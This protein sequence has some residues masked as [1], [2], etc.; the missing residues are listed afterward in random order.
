MQRTIQ[1][2]E[3]VESN[4]NFSDW[5]KNRDLLFY[6]IG[7]RWQA[8]LLYEEELMIFSSEYPPVLRFIDNKDN[9]TGGKIKSFEIEQLSFSNKYIKSNISIGL[10]QLE[11][12]GYHD[13][14]ITDNTKASFRFRGFIPVNHIN[15]CIIEFKEIDNYSV[16]EFDDKE[17]KWKNK[18]I[19]IATDIYAE[20]GVFMELQN[21]KSIFVKY[22][23]DF[24][25][26][27]ALIGRKEEM[28]N[29]K[30]FFGQLQIA[31][32][33]KSIEIRE[34]TTYNKA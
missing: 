17:Q 14:E 27:F 16:T 28:V 18:E 15:N 24:E 8:D 21:G 4:F 3:K 26:Y 23:K 9:P 10:K 29:R 6:G 22:M 25:M 33:N 30:Y 7:N 2:K 20:I 1:I 19:E 32:K 12:V 5:S 11:D 34:K 31:G 13:I